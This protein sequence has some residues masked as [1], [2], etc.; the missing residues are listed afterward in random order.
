VAV[1]R[2]SGC[3]SRY[4]ELFGRSN[5]FCNHHNLRAPGFWGCQKQLGGGDQPISVAVLRLTSMGRQEGAVIKR[6][7]VMHCSLQSELLHAA[8]GSCHRHPERLQT[9][10]VQPRPTTAQVGSSHV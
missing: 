4:I 1:H 7:P 3:C 6:D 10:F 5:M 2:E 8:P 9:I